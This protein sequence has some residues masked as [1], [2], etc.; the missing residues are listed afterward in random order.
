[1]R[2][3]SERR[4]QTT[5]Y[6]PLTIL[7][8]LAVLIIGGWLLGHVT[9]TLLTVILSGVVAFALA[10]LVSLLQRW[11]P[12]GFAIA[13]AYTVGF[14]VVLG[15]GALL[16]VTAAAQVNHLV[17]HLPEYSSE[18][19]RL[20]PQLLRILHPFGVTKA[21]LDST[22]HQL[23]T[24]LQGMGTT[25]AKDSLGIVTGIFGAII[26]VVLVLILSV[27]LVANGPQISARLRRETSG[28]HRW[29][30]VMLIGIVNQVVGGYIRGQLVL[31]ALIGTL[32][33][34]GMLILHV[35]YAVLLGV[36]AFFMAFIPIIGV[37]ISGSIC[38]SIALFQGW[39]TALLVLGYFA[40]VHVIEGEVVGP[41]IMGRAVGIH[42]ATAII[43]LVAGTEIFGFWGTLFAAPLAGLLQALGTA[44][45][46]ELRSSGPTD[47]SLTATESARRE[48]GAQDD[49]PTS[50]QA[51]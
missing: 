16:V 50:P 4:W 47:G 17:H 32:V 11:M 3:S 14:A 10:P 25:A 49:V 51:A 27:Y 15:L 44:V 29:R 13:V 1:M 6:L 33:G 43:A 2:E 31:A 9:K 8:W 22:Q 18:A 38:V 21:K 28:T 37:L 12:R 46:R 39:V 40:F 5:L 36:L 30:T 35:P 34:I 45:W 48:A 20:E 23:T 42:P 24:A 41:R 26:E 19:R 7:A